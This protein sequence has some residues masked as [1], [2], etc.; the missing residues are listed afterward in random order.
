M[1]TKNLSVENYGIKSAKVRY[2]LTADELHA[3]TLAKGQGKEASSGALAVNTG[4]FTG[5]SPQD[6]FIVEDEIT[7][8]RVWWGKINIPFS[9]QKFDALYEKV[10]AYLSG[11][12][13]YVHDGYV[14][15]DP[16][17]RTNVRTIT[18]LPWSN[19]FANNMFLRIE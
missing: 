11:K 15:A 5:R 19:L 18:E 14:C 3:E 17:Y 13:I 9:S 12:E 6:R 7:K 10:V 8:D 1:S 4:K 2:Q 16:K